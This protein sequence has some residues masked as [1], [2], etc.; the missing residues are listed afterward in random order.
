MAIPIEGNIVAEYH[1][2]ELGCTVRIS[3]AAYAGKTEAELE[4]VRREARRVA[5]GILVRAAAEEE[6]H[7]EKI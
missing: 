1:Y 6:V 2:P 5:Y 4:E 3:D 7:N